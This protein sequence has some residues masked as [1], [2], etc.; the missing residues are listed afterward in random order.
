M[1]WPFV[2]VL[3]T[4]PGAWSLAA[5]CRKLGCAFLS[6]PDTIFGHSGWFRKNFFFRIGMSFSF[7]SII[8]VAHIY[9]A[10]CDNLI[11]VYKV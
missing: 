6:A 4:S 8:L 7:I 10:L 1:R 2:L 5:Q 3:G 9:E 11:Q